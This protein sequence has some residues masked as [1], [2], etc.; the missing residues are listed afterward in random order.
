MRE[1]NFEHVR[2]VL[3]NSILSTKPS[4]CQFGMKEC[5]CLSHVTTANGEVKPDPKKIHAGKNFPQQ[6]DSWIPWI[7]RIFIENFSR[8]SGLS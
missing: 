6:T 3:R 2:E 1:D 8:L 4:K 7:D 5:T